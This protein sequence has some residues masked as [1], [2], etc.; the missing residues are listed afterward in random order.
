MSRPELRKYIRQH[1]TDDEAIH[2]L[3]VE[4]R[5]YNAPR[6]SGQMSIEEGERIIREQ[7]R[8]LPQSEINESRV[9]T[10]MEILEKVEK[11]YKQLIKKQ[12]KPDLVFKVSR[13]LVSYTSEALNQAHLEIERQIESEKI[14]A[15]LLGV[16]PLVF[17][18]ASNLSD[19]WE[20]L[21][22]AVSFGLFAICVWSKVE[23]KVTY[24]YIL[25]QSLSLKESE[26]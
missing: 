24:L 7:I 16:L 23:E 4:R 13:E 21:V 22:L 2:E 10:A 5:N 8:S 20:Y 25:K 1:S 18:T 14:L 11:R 15:T 17:V 6:Y 19:T 3:F 12:K 9:L 26:Q